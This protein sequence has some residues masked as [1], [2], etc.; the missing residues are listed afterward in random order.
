MKINIKNVN[1]KRGKVFNLQE[2]LSRTSCDISV[3]GF[4]KKSSCAIY[5][6]C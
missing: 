3:K 5:K 2:N 6:N 4:T 1:E